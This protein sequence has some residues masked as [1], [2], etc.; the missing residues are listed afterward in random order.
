MS[1]LIWN[2]QGLGHPGTVHELICLVQKYRPKL[3]FI[4]KTRQDRE[5]VR[6][7]RWRLGL[8]KCFAANGEGKGGGIALFWDESM[9]IELKSFNG[10]HID[11][12]VAESPSSAKWRATFVFCLW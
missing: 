12:L 9:T 5:C 11:V 10:R 2:Y 4:S 1:A 3:V 6:N 7:L 8:R